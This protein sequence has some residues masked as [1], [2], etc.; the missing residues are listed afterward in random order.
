MALA[1]YAII[2]EADGDVGPLDRAKLV[3]NLSLVQQMWH[4]PHLHALGNDSVSMCGERDLEQGT[5]G[6]ANF[7]VLAVG[8]FSSV[9]G[10]LL[11]DQAQKYGLF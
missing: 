3:I 6:P 5:T 8:D 9:A 7:K 4:I 10:H 2:S 1:A 11:S